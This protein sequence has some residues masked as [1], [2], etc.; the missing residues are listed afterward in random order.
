MLGSGI[1]SDSHSANPGTSYV[2]SGHLFNPPETS[3]LFWEHAG[4][5][6]SVEL[7]NWLLVSKR[8]VQTADPVYLG[9]RF[10]VLLAFVCRNLSSEAF[11]FQYL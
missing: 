8:L 10:L 2:I 1:D 4:V 5:C 7:A 9:L 3:L 6:G 11:S